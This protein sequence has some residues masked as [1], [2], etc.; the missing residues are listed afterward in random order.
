MKNI[1]VVLLFFF[2]AHLSA[3]NVGIGE[4][5]PTAMKLQVKAADSAVLLLH[6]SNGVGSN[7]KTSLFFKTGNSYAGGLATI[8]SGATFRMGM[9]TFGGAAPS[10]LIER[11]SILDGGYIGIGTT[12]P[13]YILDVNGRS[14][15]RHNGTTAGIWYNKADNTEASFVGQLNDTTFGFYGNGN[16][17]VGIDVKNALMGIGVTDPTAPLSFASSVG[18]KISLWGDATGGHYGLGIQGSLLQ[19]YSSSNAAD[20]AFGYGSSDVFTEKMRIKGNGNVGIGTAGPASKLDIANGR[21][22]LTGQVAANVAHGIEFTNNSGSILKSFLGV[23]D[24]NHFGFYGYG[25]SGWSW[26][27]NNATGDMYLGNGYDVIDK[28]KGAGY[29][30]RVDGKIISEE[31]RVQLFGSWPDYV[32]DKNYKKLS[33]DEME[34]YVILNKHLPNIP[35]AIE[36]ENNG[37]NLGELQKKMMEKIEELSLYIIELNKKIKILENKNATSALQK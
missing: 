4:N 35:S 12:S 15:I 29:K 27:I 20:I 13:T 24:D 22:R 16:W 9:F 23:L 1:L 19:L 32:F 37:Q 30:L 3:Q 7:I 6:N 25:G 28:N 11:F 5:T 17:R 26:L 34:K 18:N 10:S 33:I 31:V 21:I 36:I 8:G 14:R 2:S